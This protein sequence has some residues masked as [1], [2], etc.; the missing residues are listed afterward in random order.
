MIQFI[1]V[2]VEISKGFGSSIRIWVP[3]QMLGICIINEENMTSPGLRR[4]YVLKLH[5]NE[6]ELLVKHSGENQNRQIETLLRNLGCM[7]MV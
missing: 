7:C 6:F 2:I 1:K 4:D 3:V 5:H